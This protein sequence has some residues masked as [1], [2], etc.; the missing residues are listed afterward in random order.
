M[1][2]PPFED[3]F[4]IEHANFPPCH[5][6][7]RESI[8]SVAWNLWRF[9]HHFVWEQPRGT[10]PEHTATPCP[11][12]VD[13]YRTGCCLSFLQVFFSHSFHNLSLNESCIPWCIYPPKR[14][15]I[16]PPM[17][18]PLFSRSFFRSLPVSSVRYLLPVVCPGGSMYS[19]IPRNLQQG[20]TERT[21]K[22]GY[23]IAL[24][25][26]VTFLGGS[27]GIRS[28]S[29]L[30]SKDSPSPKNRDPEHATSILLEAGCAKMVDLRPRDRYIQ[31]WFWHF[32]F[33]FS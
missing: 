7:C 18:P 11:R 13:D 14:I 25:T 26:I 21:P 8:F 16:S 5:V 6:S 2:T 29:P 31:W 22:P 33:E 24:V 3:V 9:Q 15:N 17:Q 20:S 4:P 27:V 23:L 30:P 19:L 28:H 12:V 32:N 1:E 10:V